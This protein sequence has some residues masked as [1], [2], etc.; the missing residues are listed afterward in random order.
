MEQHLKLL[1]VVLF[2]IAIFWNLRIMHNAR[3]RLT[4]DQ[5]VSLQRASNPKAWTLLSG[6]LPLFVAYWLLETFPN[7]AVALF[8]IAIVLTF[9]AL[10][11]T[12][13]YFIRKSRQSGMPPEFVAAYRKAHIIMSVGFL[14]VIA[15]LAYPII[16]IV[17]AS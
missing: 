15:A 13:A 1:G 8:A 4:G 2:G 7:Q 10:V 17:H 14:V 3:S 12:G 16:V 6:T 5:L 11:G 9:I